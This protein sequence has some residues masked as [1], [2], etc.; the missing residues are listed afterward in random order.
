MANNIRCELKKLFTQGHTKV[1]LSKITE[2]MRQKYKLDF[3]EFGY[4]R[5]MPYFRSVDGIRIQM[6]KTGELKHP[7]ISLPVTRDV[8]WST[9]IYEMRRDVYI[10]STIAPNKRNGH[11]RKTGDY[12]E[13]ISVVEIA[14]R[15]RGKVRHPRGW[16]TLKNKHNDYVWCRKRVA[17]DTH[18]KQYPHGCNNEACDWCFETVSEDEVE[19]DPLST[20]KSTQTESK[21][22]DSLLLKDATTTMEEEHKAEI[23][24]LMIPKNIVH[25]TQG[26]FLGVKFKTE[27]SII[28][29]DDYNA[30]DA[31]RTIIALANKAGGSIYF[32]CDSIG[33]VIG[34]RKCKASLME[35]L[36][37]M[38]QQLRNVRPIRPTYKLTTKPVLNVYS[39]E[40]QDMTLVIVM[41][42]A[43]K[44]VIHTSTNKIYTLKGRAVMEMSVDDRLGQDLKFW[45]LLKKFRSI[46]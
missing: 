22:K 14:D 39:E 10:S 6:V 12:L 2:T 30:D 33:N 9:G 27:P 20:S 46:L 28:F 36:Q 18:S 5:A 13:I 3:N 7:H 17:K 26:I 31:V 25:T 21:S 37:K 24:P 35:H 23:L 34:V 4:R 19:S 44:E 38:R 32:G 40:I 15:I 16:I 43:A 29:V 42:K 41:V 8:V 11:R 1:S 45:T